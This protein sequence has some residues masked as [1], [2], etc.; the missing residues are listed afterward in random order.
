MS[1]KGSES[2]LAYLSK[3]YNRGQQLK[4]LL[5]GF[6]LIRQLREDRKKDEEKEGGK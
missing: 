2:V 6:T 1:Y 5:K 4:D 3:K